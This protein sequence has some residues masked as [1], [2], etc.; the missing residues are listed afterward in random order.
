MPLPRLRLSS[1][2]KGACVIG[3]GCLLL[4]GSGL[5]LQRAWKAS[6]G[7]EVEGRVSAVDAERGEITVRF[8]G[9]RR[10]REERFEVGAEAQR[11][12][13]GRRVR[14]IVTG[15]DSAHLQGQGPG[16]LPILVLLLLGGATIGA[17][18]F[19]LLR[20]S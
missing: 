2:A 16:A 12:R 1:R 11:L 15:E 4:L 10:P 18:T 9:L 6:N 7:S 8:P 17:G 3:L 5:L 19:V 14:V 20:P 13:P